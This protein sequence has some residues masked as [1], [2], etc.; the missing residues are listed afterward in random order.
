M[1]KSELLARKIEIEDAARAC[2]QQYQH[3]EKGFIL[4]RISNLS[5]NRHHYTSD[6]SKETLLNALVFLLYGEALININRA[7]E[8]LRSFEEGPPEFPAVRKIGPQNT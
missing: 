2:W 1:S 8:R 3:E 6:D 7:L 5:K 4:W